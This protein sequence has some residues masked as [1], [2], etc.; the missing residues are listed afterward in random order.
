MLFFIQAGIY[1]ISI[2]FVPKE[3]DTLSEVNMLAW[4]ALSHW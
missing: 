2:Q 1:G 4:G 3:V